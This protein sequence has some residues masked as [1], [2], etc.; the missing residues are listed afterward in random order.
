[1]KLLAIDTST[2]KA[3]I[4]LAIG[5]TIHVEEFDGVREHAEH[6]LPMI[7]RVL[8]MS[9]CSLSQLDG[10]VLGR[11]PGSFTG[12]RVA[13][14]I[15]KGLAFA[16]NLPIYPVSSLLAIADEAYQQISPNEAQAYVLAV[17][18]ARMS[19]VYWAHYPKGEINAEEIVSPALQ[20]K[21]PQG[22]HI[23][24]AGVG[25]DLD[26][27]NVESALLKTKTIYPHAK[28]MIRIV[29]TYPIEAQHAEDVLPIYIRNQVVQG[30]SRG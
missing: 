18:D 26:D 22:E 28:A 29:Q 14:S 9:D 19:E 21:V 10:I 5:D 3:S 23:I 15:A 13:T 2:S 8:Q 12:L 27:F 4:A 17:L 24:L 6:L 20:V 1:M 30:E 25:I 7:E 11:G 16:H